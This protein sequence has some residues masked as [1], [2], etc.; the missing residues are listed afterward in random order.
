[1]AGH[2]WS[3]D[4]KTFKLVLTNK[5][6]RKLPIGRL[7]L[8]WMV[9][10]IINDFKSINKR[11][12][13]DSIYIEAV[14]TN[15]MVRKAKKKYIYTYVTIHN[16]IIIFFI[17]LMHSQIWPLLFLYGRRGFVPKNSGTSDAGWYLTTKH[18]IVTNSHTRPQ[19]YFIKKYNFQNEIILFDVNMF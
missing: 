15:Q 18:V 2:V 12:I 17:H 7:L 10:V 11:S 4:E 5:P 16:N 3:A 8:Y 13:S 1:M 9:R 6:H 19:Y 14:K